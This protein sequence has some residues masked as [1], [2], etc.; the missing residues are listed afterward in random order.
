MLI[1]HSESIQN[2]ISNPEGLDLRSVRPPSQLGGKYG[3]ETFSIDE[4]QAKVNGK[5]RYTSFA[6]NT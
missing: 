5:Y 1:K 4:A 6:T 2:K 3:H